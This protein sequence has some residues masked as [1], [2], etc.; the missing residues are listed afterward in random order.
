TR[1]TTRAHIA[2]AALES[3]ALKSADV[4][5]AM[6]KDAGAPLRELRVD[7]GAARND[8][9]M[10]FQADILG[11]P[12]VRPRMTETTALGAAYLAGLAV[13]Y[14]QSTAELTANWQSERRFEPQMPAAEAAA[15]LDEWRRAVERARAWA[16]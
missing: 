6:Q 11:V 15:R 7:G 5:E 9:L 13:G 1:G 16:R 12:V 2:R 10:Q 3:S 8:L 14:W 4:V